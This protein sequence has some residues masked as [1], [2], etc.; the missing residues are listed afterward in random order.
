M[1]FVLKYPTRGR[2]TQFIRMVSLYQRLLSHRHP[3]RFVVSID[4]DD[5]T[6][7]SLDVRNFLRRARGVDVYSGKSTG[8]IAAVNADMDKLGDYDVLILMSD[9]MIPQRRGYDVVIEQLMRQHFPNLDG[10]LHFSDGLNHAGLNTM[11]IVGRR[12]I[13]E[14]GYIYHPDYKAEF[15]D[16]HFQCRSEKM[17][18]SVRINQILFKHDWTKA[19]GQDATFKRNSGFW[20]QDKATFE[21]HK[22]LGFP[23]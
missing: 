16:N 20:E 9:D 14:Q 10:C 6:M 21:R 5:S 18:K 23:K 12:F 22:A 1:R 17:G 3:A 11:P 15:C 7:R 8:K 19:T 2:P 13:E 4:D